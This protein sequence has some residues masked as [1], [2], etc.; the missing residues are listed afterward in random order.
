MT[1]SEPMYD[2]RRAAVGEATIS[3]I[4][5]LPNA[6]SKID[7][8]YNEQMERALIAAVLNTDGQ[9]WPV[10]SEIVQ[11]GDFYLRTCLIIW[12]AFE[13]IST[14]GETLDVFSVSAK[15]RDALKNEQESKAIVEAMSTMLSSAPTNVLANVEA[16]ARG[17][18]ALAARRRLLKA[19]VE[20]HIAA[21]DHSGSLDSLITYAVEQVAKASEGQ[22]RTIFSSHVSS[23]VERLRENVNRLRTGETCRIRTGWRVLDEICKG[24]SAGDVVVVGGYTGH[25]KTTWLLSL[26]YNLLTGFERELVGGV[27]ESQNPVPCAIFSLEQDEMDVVRALASIITSIPQSK[28]LEGNLSDQ[29]MEMFEEALKLIEQLPLYIFDKSFFP[30]DNPLTPARMKRLSKAIQ[31]ELQDQRCMILIDGI[32]LMNA[33][34][35]YPSAQR[36]QEVKA[37]MKGL[38]DA[39]Q[40]LGVPIIAMHQYTDDYVTRLLGNN[41]HNR[42]PFLTD[43]SESASVKRDAP[44]AIGLHNPG[45]VKFTPDSVGK[46]YGYVLKNRNRGGMERGVIEYHFDRSSG[47]YSEYGWMS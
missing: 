19:A 9:I 33:N 8:L 25:G 26:L 2:P 28:Y 37:L 10:V 23:G 43:F 27:V 3:K 1:N 38:L 46:M 45:M 18:A 17:V 47:S 35:K 13:V 4:I 31:S 16:W 24:F 34:E 5:Q 36:P 12:R 7:S 15:I 41:K 14:T 22:R 29:E 42:R 40:D 39:S 20:I 11:A 30:K 6:T 32:W 21:I 44:I